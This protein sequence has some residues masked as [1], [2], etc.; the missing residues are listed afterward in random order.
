MTPEAKAPGVV[1]VADQQCACVQIYKL[2]PRNNRQ[3]VGELSGG[4]IAY[5]NN[6]TTDRKGNLWIANWQGSNVLAYPPGATSPSITLNDSG[7]CAADVAVGP[8]GKVYVANAEVCPGS[9]GS[10]NIVIYAKGSTTPQKTLA[11]P[12]FGNPTGIAVD[13]HRNIFVTNNKA[14]NAIVGEFKAGSNGSYTY[15]TLVSAPNSVLEG[16]VIDKAGNLIVANAFFPTLPGVN[17]YSP[18]N[19]DLTN[20]FGESGAFLVGL[21]FVRDESKIFVTDLEGNG[22]PAVYE[23]AYPT[24]KQLAEI[25]AGL[26]GPVGVAVAPDA[27]LGP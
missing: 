16:I 7:Y 19:W 18:P 5:P 23:Y 1:Y 22:G 11:D 2:R 21:A 12:S 25:T 17:V 4:A 10:G 3:P 8:N 13:A 6:I 26:N 24:G 14:G 9:S 20:Q 15:A 27:P